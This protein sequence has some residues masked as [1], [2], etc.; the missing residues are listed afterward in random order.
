M[1]FNTGQ[2]FNSRNIRPNYPPGEGPFRGDQYWDDFFSNFPQ[3]GVGHD[4]FEFG[5][6][7]STPGEQ[8]KDVLKMLMDNPNV[9]DKSPKAHLDRMA[10]M[11]KAPR[12]SD[13]RAMTPE[14]AMEKMKNLSPEKMAEGEDALRKALMEV[15]ADDMT[16]DQ[17]TKYE[18]IVAEQGELAGDKYLDELMGFVEDD[19]YLKI[20]N[21]AL[22]KFDVS[23]DVY[24]KWMR[25]LNKPGEFDRELKNKLERVLQEIVDNEPVPKGMSGENPLTRKTPLK[26]LT[27]KALRAAAREAAR[28]MPSKMGK[29]ARDPRTY[30]KLAKGIGSAGL[31]VL[32]EEGGLAVGEALSPS[33]FEPLPGPATTTPAVP[34]PGLSF[35]FGDV[36]SPNV[37]NPNTVQRFGRAPGSPEEEIMR[38]LVQLLP[39]SFGMGQNRSPQPPTTPATQIPRDQM[40]EAMMKRKRPGDRGVLPAARGGRGGLPTQSR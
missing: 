19:D 39:E 30:A 16:P 38:T 36:E 22:K 27:A 37:P 4:P 18:K 20:K 15:E 35:M 2:P 6:P 21:D 10:E 29:V 24:D 17:L 8:V 3:R 12:P 23:A 9:I 40:L 32:A 5:R 34:I 31:G 25:N 7:G 1:N 28:E 14:E 13:V 33:F 26:S 11:D